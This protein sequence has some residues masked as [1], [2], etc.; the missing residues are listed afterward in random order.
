[1]AVKTQQL[2]SSTASKRPTAS[3]LLD[4]ELAL[5]LD[6]GTPGAFFEDANGAIVKIGPAE[7][8]GTAPNASPAAGGSSGNTTG[9]LWFDTA[10]AGGNAQDALKV[11][12]GSN[13]VNIGQVTLGATN[14]TLGASTTTVVQGMSL[15][16]SGVFTAL[17]D[18]EV[19]F[20]ESLTN[21]SN[22]IAFKAP[23]FV[24]TNTTFILPDGDGSN[25]NVLQTNGSGVLAW[26]EGST[27]DISDGDTFVSVNGNTDTIVFHTAGANRAIFGP[28]GGFIPAVDSTVDIGTTTLRWKDLYI[29]SITCGGNITGTW[30][31]STISAAKGGTG[32]DASSAANGS[33]LIGNGSGLTL[34][35]L[36]PGTGLTITN[37]SGSITPSITDTGVSAAAYGSATSIPTFTVNAQGQLTAAA[38]LLISIPH[39]QVNDFDA[40][41]QTNRLD[42]MAAP[43]AAVSFNNQKITDL[44]TPTGDLDAANK[45]YVDSVAEGLDSKQSCYVATAAALPA[46]TYA[47]GVAGVGATLTANGVGALTVDGEAIA[48]TGLRILVK[49]QAAQLQ[50]GIYVVTTVGTGSATFVL[51]RSEDCDT[52]EQILHAFTFI[53]NG[54]TTADNGYTC[55]ATEPIT[56]GTTALPWTQFSGAGQITAGAGMTKTGNTLNVNGTANRITANADD[57][58]IASTYVGQTSITTLGTVATGTWNATIIGKAYGGTGVDNSTGLTASHAFMAPNGA[59]GAASF[60]EILTSDIAPTTGG[61]FDA[62]TY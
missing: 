6:A 54:N 10:N 51:T 2:R 23:S 18:G 43:T 13:F 39:T 35:T 25:G 19:R 29:D 11:F 26:G 38:N 12:D 8:G 62:G 41:V 32:I 56:M 61:S 33:L 52:S 15:L 46:V 40:G 1:M 16:T 5:N 36:T 48:T 59:S 34:T 9:E 21:G 57:I 55:T 4:G 44:A 47:N 37:A 58:D 30:D 45:G 28:A 49:D 22:Y 14:I 31:G 27:N 3:A 7:V 17:N 24:T 42:Q 20:A 60:R 50:N 53:E